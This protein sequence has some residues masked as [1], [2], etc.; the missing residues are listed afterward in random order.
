MFSC[1]FYRVGGEENVNT[2]AFRRAIWKYIQAIKGIRHDDYN[3]RE[4]CLNSLIIHTVHCIETYITVCFAG[5]SS[6]G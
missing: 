4:V 3:Y 2:D 5:E 6:I 1:L